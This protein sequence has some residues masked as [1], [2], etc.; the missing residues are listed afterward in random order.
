MEAGAPETVAFAI[1]G[2]IARGD[3]PSLTERV[4]KQ[5]E[6]SA[7][8]TA[9]C[10]VRGVEPDAVTVDALARLQLG[11]GRHH[12]RVR[13]QNASP[14][15]L[16]LVAFMGLENVLSGRPMTFRRPER[17]SSVKHGG[18]GM[19]QVLVLVA[20]RKGCFVLEGDA[21]RRDWELRGPY[22]ESWPVYHAI[23]DPESGTFYAAAGSEWHGSAIWRSP[24]LGATWE[25]SSEG[26]SYEGSDLKLSKVSNVTA[27]HGRVLVGG[28]GA[29]LFESTDGA[30][31]SR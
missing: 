18:E 13:L 26:L 2:P 14:E 24:D 19:S 11:A 8:R 15:L 12:C 3:L 28:E 22:C 5:L 9:L 10:D 1:R 6:R 4:C 20:T 29:G 21:D 31:P 7:G 30:R 25:H 23:H 17:L 16:D 27:A